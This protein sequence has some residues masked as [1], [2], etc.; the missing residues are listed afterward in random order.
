[1]FKNSPFGKTKSDD[2]TNNG[3]APVTDWSDDASPF[4]APS[5][6][7]EASPF[8]TTT[9]V[10]DAPLNTVGSLGTISARNVLNSDVSVVGILRFSDELLVDGSVEGEITSDGIL[11]VGNNATIVA[12][13]KNKTAIRTK[14]AIIHGKVSGNVLVEDLVELAKDS[15][16]IGDITAARLI[17]N[18]GAIFI[19]RSTV[20][21]PSGKFQN[22]NTPAKASKG[23]PTKP[24]AADAKPEMGD[25]LS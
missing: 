22:M 24:A 2:N 16:L 10:S 8:G 12:Q 18:D 23:K 3:D 9:P 14:S 19:G 17:V 6:F 4:G 25:L 15:E 11:T 7:E 5:S 1:M 20:G 13:E 21:V